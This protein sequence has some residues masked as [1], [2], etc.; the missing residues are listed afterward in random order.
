M[1][2]HLSTKASELLFGKIIS[3]NKKESTIKIANIEDGLQFGGFDAPERITST[4]SSKQYRVIVATQDTVITG[5]TDSDGTNMLSAGYLGQFAS[6][7][8]IVKGWILRAK[9]DKTIASV[10]ISSGEVWGLK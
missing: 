7:D 4:V 2:S 1:F 10:T 6:G 3:A 9:K 5:L 8:T